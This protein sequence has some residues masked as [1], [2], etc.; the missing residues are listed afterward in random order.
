MKVVLAREAAEQL[1]AQVA[2]L[3]DVH[4]LQAAERFKSRVLSFLSNHLA[5]FPRT[6][7]KLVDRELWEIWIPGTR[8]ILWY[9]I[10]DDRIE[11]ATVWHS[12]QDRSGGKT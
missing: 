9:R 10:D 12:A 6:G 7:R 1:E 4:A 11:I 3:R 2:Y 8:L 5:H